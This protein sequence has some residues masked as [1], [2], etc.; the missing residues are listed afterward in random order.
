MLGRELIKIIL[1]KGMVDEEIKVV[2]LND[3]GINLDTVVNA[4]ISEVDNI[5]M[6]DGDTVPSIVIEAAIILY[7]ILHC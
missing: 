3:G 5:E 6:D 4:C 2:G 7:K 1:D